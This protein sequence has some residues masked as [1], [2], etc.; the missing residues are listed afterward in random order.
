ML[1]PM[2]DGFND[3]MSVR[4]RRLRFRCWH[5]GSREAD[6]L[7]GRFADAEIDHL[8]AAGL[9]QLEALLEQPDPDIWNWVVGRDPVPA[10]FDN[11]IV[12][13]LIDLSQR[14]R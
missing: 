2:S 4:R 7:L 10:A 9:D 11:A 1:A 13:R 5:R 8:D 14:L 6:L 12:A 3:D